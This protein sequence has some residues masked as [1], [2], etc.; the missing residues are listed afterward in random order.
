MKKFI[1]IFVCLLALLIPAQTETLAAHN[2]IHHSSNKKG[3]TII[4]HKVYINGEVIEEI[5]INQ[6]K[7]LVQVKKEFKG[8]KVIEENDDQIVLMKKINDLSPTLKSKG[9]LGINSNGVLNLYIGVPSGN[10][11]IESF[12]QIDTNKLEVNK[13]K[14]LEKGIKISTKNHYDYLLHYLKEYERIVN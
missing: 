1:L 3:I 9:Y 13:Q 14:Q 4:L 11:I 2:D 12:F 10:N 8:W 5:Y 7:T 6:H